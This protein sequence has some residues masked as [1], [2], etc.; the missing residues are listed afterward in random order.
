MIGEIDDLSRPDGLYELRAHARDGAGNERTS[1]RRRDGSK[2]HL[3]IPLRLA[4]R[5]A[6][7][8]AR[9]PLRCKPR[10]SHRRGRCGKRRAAG[11]VE[12]RGRHGLVRGLVETGGGEP[13][14]HAA[15]AVSEQLRTGGAFTRL[16]TLRADALGRF[17]YRIGPGQSRTVRFRYA[18]TAL[19]K[20]AAGDV[21]VLV[22][23]RSSIAV[24]RRKV[25]NGDEVAFSGALRGGYVPEGGKLI[26]L[27]AYYRGGWRTFATARTD[28]A[29]RW[30]YRYRFGATRGVVRYRFRA[31]IR[32]EAAYP[33]ELGYSKVVRVT[34]RG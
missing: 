28:A 15:V 9:R 26:D 34:V 13:I 19:V 31:R 12:V 27:Q 23:A 5:I 25:L 21:K 16:A 33:F 1:D 2:V 30:A 7:A 32:R 14:P 24:D 20:P 8:T 4:T 6:L 18:G 17:A 11:S 29:G 3:R 22:P 10:R